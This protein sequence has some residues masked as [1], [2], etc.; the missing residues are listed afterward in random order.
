MSEINTHEYVFK[1]F[2]VP[3]GN[4]HVR[5]LAISVDR[6]QKELQLYRWGEDLSMRHIGVVRLGSLGCGFELDLHSDA[7]YL[8]A[9]IREVLPQAYP[10]LRDD[11]EIPD[12]MAQA[13]PDPASGD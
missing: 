13:N 11:Y 3:V 1:G 5:I 7:Q 8:D 10:A 9:G 2:W 6:F 4:D 12:P